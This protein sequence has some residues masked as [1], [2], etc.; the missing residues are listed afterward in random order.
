ME[1]HVRTN[2]SESFNAIVLG[3]NVLNMTGSKERENDDKN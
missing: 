1:G 3:F 2:R